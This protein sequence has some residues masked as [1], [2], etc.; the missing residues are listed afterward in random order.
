MFVRNGCSRWAGICNPT[1]NNVEAI[2]A[3]FEISPF[4]FL[5][6]ESFQQNN[7]SGA[8]IERI[9]DNL[10]KL[11]EREIEHVVALVD[12]LASQHDGGH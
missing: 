10:D 4:R 9:I 6:A 11:N 3:A 7:V 8:A 1:L 12:L 5:L 2:A